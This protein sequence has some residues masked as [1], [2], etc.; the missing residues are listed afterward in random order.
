[1]LEINSIT[2]NPISAVC[3]SQTEL[4]DNEHKLFIHFTYYNFCLEYLYV[5]NTFVYKSGFISSSGVKINQIK[6]QWKSIEVESG[7]T[8]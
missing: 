3:G 7:E 1:M 5:Y 8:F 6:A 2:L 4:K